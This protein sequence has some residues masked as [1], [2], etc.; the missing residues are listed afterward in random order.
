[1]LRMLARSLDSKYF[2][3]LP[4]SICVHVFLYIFALYFLRK[5]AFLR[6]NF[7]CKYPQIPANSRNLHN[8]CFLTFSVA[9]RFVLSDAEGP[10]EVHLNHRNFSTFPFFHTEIYHVAFPLEKNRNFYCNA[11][12]VCYQVLWHIRIWAVTFTAQGY[13]GHQAGNIYECGPVSYT[14]LTLPTILRV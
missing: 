1:M 2:D 11:A 5:S 10:P 4:F 7:I 13:L 14:H 12:F 3:R 9:R 8:S 6:D